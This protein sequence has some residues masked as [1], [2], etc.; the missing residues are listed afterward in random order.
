[1]YPSSCPGRDISGATLF[2]SF[3]SV[4]HVF[5]IAPVLDERGVPRPLEGRM[6]DGAIS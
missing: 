1:M 3:S 4:L 5:T 6:S 2:A